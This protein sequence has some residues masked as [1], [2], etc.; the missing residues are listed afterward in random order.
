[1][2]GE[3]TEALGSGKGRWPMAGTDTAVIRL[4]DLSHGQEAVCFAALVKKEKGLDKHGNPFIKCHFRDKLVTLVAPLWSGNALREE[5]E[6]WPDGQAFRLHVRGDRNI[7]Y[8]MQLEILAAR[9]AVDADAV[10][11]YDFRDLVE[12]SDYDPEQLFKTIHD[13]IQRYIDDLCLRQLVQTLLH[14]HGPLFKKMPAA[15]NFHH[16]YTAGLLEH[17]WSMTRIAGFLA[18]HYAKYYAQLNPP[19]NKGVIVAAAIL[20]DIG[21][22]RELDYHPVETKYTKEGQ[23]IGHVLIGRDMVREAARKIE[24]FSEETLLLLEHAILSH[25][26]KREFGAPIAPLTLEALLVSYVDELDAKMNSAARHRMLSKTEDEFTDKIYPLDNR[27]FYKGIPAELPAE[28][29]LN[30]LP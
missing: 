24:G 7:R 22:L 1:M 10:D 25:H 14:E 15:Q 9:L 16:S 12:S 21:K 28:H 2:G 29:E 26:G 4:S 18:D 17:V 13:L 27:R 19:L 11:G 5:A 8:G 6:D 20:H 3:T 23:L 30:D